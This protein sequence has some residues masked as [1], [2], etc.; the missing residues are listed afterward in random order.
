MEQFS[1]L[2]L[3]S[4]LSILKNFE[5]FKQMLKSFSHFNS[6]RN[7]LQYSRHL[8]STYFQ[9]YFPFSLACLV[10]TS[11]WNDEN[12]WKCRTNANGNYI[13]CPCNGIR[14]IQKKKIKIP[15]TKQEQSNYTRRSRLN[16]NLTCEFCKCV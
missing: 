5:Y 12:K 15:Q 9:I 7:V 14:I 8:S 13:Q 11:F 2:V 3:K 1:V 4:I 6:T 10:Y 16:G